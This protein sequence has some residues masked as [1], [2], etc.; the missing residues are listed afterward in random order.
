MLHSQL[1]SLES[2]PS[3]NLLNLDALEAISPSSLP[4]WATLFQFILPPSTTHLLALSSFYFIWFSS[5]SRMI[6]TR[7]A[8]I[9]LMQNFIP[10][11][12]NLY[13]L[14]YSSQTFFHLLNLCCPFFWWIF[15]FPIIWWVLFFWWVWIFACI[16]FRF[17]SHS[18]NYSRIP[19]L[20]ILNLMMLLYHQMLAIFCVLM[21]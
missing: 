7:E 11:H 19:A 21:V 13:F 10:A 2:N 20:F 18:M 15:S 12:T 3:L 16:Y 6:T 1:A 5:I 4:T 9:I 14:N 8:S 17:L